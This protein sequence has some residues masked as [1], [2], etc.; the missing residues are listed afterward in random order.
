MKTLGF[1]LFLL[2]MLV[3]IA[4]SQESGQEGPGGTAPL[5]GG[6]GSAE[7]EEL[8]A[9]ERLVEAALFR[10]RQEVRYEP[11]YVSIDYPG[12]DVPAGTGVCTDVVIR[13]YRAAFGID[14]QKR[15]HEDMKANFSEYPRLWGLSGTDRNIDHRRVPNL[16]RFFQRQGAERELAEDSRF[17]PGDLVAWDLTGNGL[18]HIGI[19]VDGD[20]FVHN[21]GAGPEMSRGIRQWK[22]VGHYRYLPDAE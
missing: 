15:V 1:L 14:L 9:P 2:W 7:D 16:Q 10:T 19:V 20:T 22:V 17:L 6:V 18:W 11:A 5:A 4:S 8:S 21:I 13:S 12:G 3:Q